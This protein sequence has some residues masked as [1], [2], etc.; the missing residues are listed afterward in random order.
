MILALFDNK[1]LIYTNY[2]PQGNTMNAKYIIE[3]LDKFL[4]IFKQKRP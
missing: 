2:G 4:E 1:G 3:A